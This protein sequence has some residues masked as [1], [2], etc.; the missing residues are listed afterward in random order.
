MVRLIA[1]WMS[2]Y[3]NVIIAIL[4]EYLRERPV[5]VEPDSWKSHGPKSPGPITRFNANRSSHVCHVNVTDSNGNTCHVI[6]RSCNF[7]PLC[8]LSK[9][10]PFSQNT[11][12]ASFLRWHAFLRDWQT[13]NTRSRPLRPLLSLRPLPNSHPRFLPFLNTFFFSF[14]SLACHGEDKNLDTLSLPHLRY[15]DDSSL[16]SSPPEE[17]RQDVCL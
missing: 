2:L 3:S 13:S 9:V 7:N 1:S 6:Y 17:R 10:N 12:I 16:N 11:K 8:L 15:L 4:L 5:G 14:I